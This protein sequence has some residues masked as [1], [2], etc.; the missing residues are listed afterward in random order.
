MRPAEVLLRRGPP[1]QGPQVGGAPGP[2]LW[3]W[4]ADRWHRGDPGGLRRLSQFSSGRAGKIFGD[5]GFTAT[6]GGN[7]GLVEPGRRGTYVSDF[8]FPR[9]VGSAAVAGAESSP[10][11]VGSGPNA[12]HFQP[13]R[14]VLSGPYLFHAC[15]FD[16]FPQGVS[17]CGFFLK[18][19]LGLARKNLRKAAVD[20]VE[21]ET[22]PARDVSGCSSG[23]YLDCLR[24]SL[25]IA[26]S[27]TC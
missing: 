9:G 19:P 21:G 24:A 16:A 23:S 25:Y 7:R 27:I 11:P 12:P 13:G 10:S 1:G 4:R 22:A 18:D 20:P 5:R 2:K 6:S 15:G 8:K 17:G 14:G 26:N 3:D